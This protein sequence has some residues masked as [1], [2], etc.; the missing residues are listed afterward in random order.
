MGG[1]GLKAAVYG[2]I[3]ARC[4]YPSYLECCNRQL[5]NQNK[6]LPLKGMAGS[7]WVEIALANQTD[8]ARFN[9]AIDEVLWD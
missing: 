2:R 5:T 6:I 1:G 8:I 9:S 4:R 7:N 3:S